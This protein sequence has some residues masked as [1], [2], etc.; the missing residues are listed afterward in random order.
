LNSTCSFSHLFLL[1]P[2]VASGRMALAV[3]CGEWGRGRGSGSIGGCWRGYGSGA[4]GWTR[5]DAQVMAVDVGMRLCQP[6]MKKRHFVP[7]MK[8]KLKVACFKELNIFRGSKWKAVR[9]RGQEPKG[10]H[11]ERARTKISLLI[12]GKFLY[13]HQLSTIKNFQLPYWPSCLMFFLTGHYHVKIVEENSILSL[14]IFLWPI[15]VKMFYYCQKYIL[16]LLKIQNL[17]THVV[18]IYKLHIN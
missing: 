7:Q 15:V 3:A 10:S 8:W 4:D 12:N 17:H 5:V 1:L 11:I 14:T 18:Q 16:L 2:H 6:E 13:G 9:F